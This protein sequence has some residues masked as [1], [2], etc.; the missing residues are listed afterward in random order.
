MWLKVGTKNALFVLWYIA[1]RYKNY[2]NKDKVKKYEH[3]YRRLDE[4][5]RNSLE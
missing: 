5:I 1:I 4:A 2:K 3:V